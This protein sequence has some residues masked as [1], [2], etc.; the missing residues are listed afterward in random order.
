MATGDLFSLG[1]YPLDIDAWRLTR[2]DANV[3]IGGR[4]ERIFEN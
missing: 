3:R 2:H 1:P 4:S